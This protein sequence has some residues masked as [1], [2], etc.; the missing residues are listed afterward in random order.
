MKLLLQAALALAALCTLPGAAQ[1]SVTTHYAGSLND[2]SNAALV[3]SQLG[4][5]DVTQFGDDNYVAN[6]VGL[7]QFNVAVGGTVS[8]ASLGGSAGGIDPYFSL[9]TGTGN[10]ATFTHSEFAAVLGV[11]FTF[12]LILAAGDYTMSI[13]AFEN[14]SFAENQGG[15]LGDGFIGLGVPALGNYGYDFSITQSGNGLVVPEPGAAALALTA[16]LMGALGTGA[17]RRRVSTGPDAHR[18]TT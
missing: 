2:A 3:D 11:N 12:D 1:A 17:A 5:P 13:G 16:L 18:S 7:Y 8:F 6:L 9:F 10:G 4:A 15:S 14:M